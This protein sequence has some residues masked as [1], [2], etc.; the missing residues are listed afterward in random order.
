MGL[1]QKK[2]TPLG[3]LEIYN[4]GASKISLDHDLAKLFETGQTLPLLTTIKRVITT[5]AYF[6]NCDLIDGNNNLFNR[7]RAKL[8]AKFDVTG[9][10]Y[11]KVRY[12][13]SPQ[14]PIRDCSTDSH[15]N[16][17]TLNV[18]DQDGELFDFKGMPIAP[19]DEPSLYPQLSPHDFRMQKANE[20][21]AALNSEVAHYRGVA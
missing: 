9:K 5:T 18:R 11:Q 20:V 16:S 8:L 13:A 12:D 10:T 21:A 14:Q 7:K 1:R 3:Q 6:I 4:F 2:N 19:H 15:V 17:I